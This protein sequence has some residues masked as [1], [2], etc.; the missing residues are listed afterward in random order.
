M[1]RL[2]VLEAAAAEVVLVEAPTVAAVA[3]GQALVAGQGARAAGAEVAA[4]AAG[5]EVAARPP[6]PA[7]IRAFRRR[8]AAAS[9]HGPTPT[10]AGR[11]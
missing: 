10:R 7:Q 9:A 4:R 6:D 5:A 11:A 8:P 3:G 2:L 1:V